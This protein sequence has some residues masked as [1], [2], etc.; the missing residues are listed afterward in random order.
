MPADAILP[1]SIKL[2]LTALFETV[3]FIGIRDNFFVDD[4]LFR[5]TGVFSNV[6]PTGRCLCL[7]NKYGTWFNPGFT[8]R[9]NE[10]IGSI[11]LQ[12]HE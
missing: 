6:P 1:V 5:C 12:W 11:R 10:K 8:D 3:E 4:T 2:G 9:H 7:L